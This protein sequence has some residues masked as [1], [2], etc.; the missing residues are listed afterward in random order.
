MKFFIESPTIDTRKWD[1]YSNTL[2]GYSIKHPIDLQ[3]KEQNY[4]LIDN[5]GGVP[6]DVHF[7]EHIN[8]VTRI[9][10]LP[11]TVITNLWSDAEEV[12]FP[13]FEALRRVRN[14]APLGGGSLT[15]SIEY[16]IR[17]RG[18]DYVLAFNPAT[19]ESPGALM[20]QFE[21]MVASFS[22][23]SQPNYTAS[24]IRQSANTDGFDFPTDPKDGSTGRAPSYADYDVKNP[25]LSGWSSCYNKSMSELQHAAEDF[26]R[27]S[28]SNVYAVANGQV[29]W[30]KDANYP[31]A[32]V[33]VKH[34]LPSN[35][36]SPW[37]G[38]TIYSVYIG[39]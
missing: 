5:Y 30:S 13:N 17:G 2:F 12:I 27:S 38:D 37:N 33:I 35:V 25:Y 10:P 28:G 31:G 9:P 15:M 11:D 3:P 26:F 14:S 32:V 23:L 19:L 8:I 4:S 39:L 1:T 16:L 36:L 34:T 21:R 18:V 20:E 22:I 7:D 29:V 24:M 6:S